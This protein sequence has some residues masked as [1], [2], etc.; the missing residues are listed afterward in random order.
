M[1]RTFAKTMFGN[2]ARRLQA[3]H[4]S[5]AGYERIAER[6]PIDSELGPD[7]S[8]FIALRDSFYLATVTADGWPYIQHRGGPVGFLHVLTPRTLAF[9]D[10]AGNKQYISTGNL[11]TNDRVALFLMD[12]PHQTRLKI[13]GHAH[14]LEQGADPAL[15][16]LLTPT[17]ARLERLVTISVV[18]FD[19]NCPQ[20]ITPRFTMEEIASV[21]NLQDPRQESAP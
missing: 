3:A 19:W 2:A 7:E 20:H 6:G 4:G 11:D 18:A 8:A 21:L 9:A 17:A 14:I 5:R 10:L 1:G 12:Y 16:S 13:I 15:E